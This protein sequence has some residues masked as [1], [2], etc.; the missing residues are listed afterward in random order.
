VGALPQ[1][2]V[3]QKL[4]G[5][6]YSNPDGNPSTQA[7]HHQFRH[8]SVTGSDE[9]VLS[10]ICVLDGKPVTAKVVSPIEIT[11]DTIRVLKTAYDSQHG[12]ENTPTCDASID[13][14]VF[15]YTF[16]EEDER[17]TLTNP[18]GNPDMLDL[19]RQQGAGQEAT[20]AQSL[21]GSWL[22]PTANSK[23]FQMQTRY[24]FFTTADHHDTLREVAVCSKGNDSIVAD[25]DT[26][27]T[28]T[29]DRITIPE[30]A[31]KEQHQ[32][33]FACKVTIPAGTWRYTVG[34]GGL[35]LSVSINGGK[36]VTLTREANTGLN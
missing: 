15:S 13:A 27:V 12:R 32:G 10:R 6:W 1:N 20:P 21:Y 31:T 35:T 2:T 36:P 7:M 3:A 11:D 24:V 16:S 22:Q 5:T 28:I 33:M 19:V 30:A 9:I 18:G 29:K 17:L 34:P 23:E 26:E 25:V 14:G 8:N 4:Y